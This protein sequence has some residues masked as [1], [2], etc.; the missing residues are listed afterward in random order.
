MRKWKYGV[1]A[2]PD[3]PKTAPI[4]LKGDICHCLREAAAIG[5]DAIEYHTRENAEFDIAEIKRTMQETGCRISMLVTGRLYTEGHYSLTSE[6]PENEKTALEGLLRYIDMAAALECGIVIGW[7]KGNIRESSSRES[8]FKKLTKNLK[9]LDQSAF[10]KN[11]PIVIEVIN[12]Y[13]VDVFMTAEETSAY[14]QEQGFK[15]CFVHLD[16]FHMS[17]EELNF[18]KAIQTAGPRLGY[19]HLADTTRWYPGSGY[20]DYKPIMRTLEQA[21]YSGYLTIE[22][23]PHENAKETA[24]KGLRYLKVLEDSLF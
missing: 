22:C 23:F 24:E 6:D 1:S 3:A 13:E 7:A 12:H 16:T 18:V 19:V 2:A 5:F 8:Y 10:E 21:G 11:V 15:S 20:M 9:I 4:L 14:I 17:L